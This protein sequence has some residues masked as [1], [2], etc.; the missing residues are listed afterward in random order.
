MKYALLAVLTF[1]LFISCHHQEASRQSL[2]IANHGS[3]SDQVP[4]LDAEARGE[5][6]HRLRGLKYV[7]PEDG[8]KG[9][10]GEHVPEEVYE[11][12]RHAAANELD[13]TYT[14]EKINQELQKA[15]ARRKQGAHFYAGTDRGPGNISGRAQNLIVDAADPTQ[16]TW[17]VAAHGG[18]LWRTRN[19]GLHWENLTENLG[20]LVVTCVAQSR[21]QPQTLYIGTGSGHPGGLVVG[22]GM[23][24]SVDSGQSWQLLEST[25]VA[26]WPATVNDILV[27][28][29]DPN[30]IIATG[31]GATSNDPNR[32]LAIMRSA[33]GG[34]SWTVV[35]DPKTVN[36]DQWR[37]IYQ[38]VA[39]PDAFDVLYATLD[40]G[41]ILRSVDRGL[42]WSILHTLEGGRI[43]IALAPSN[44][45]IIYGSVLTESKPDVIVSRDGG[46]SWT[47]VEDTGTDPDFLGQ[48]DYVMAI[49]VHPFD[50]QIVYLSGVYV[51]L[52]RITGDTRIT[53]A[54]RGGYHV[55]VHGMTALFDPAA[56][57]RFRLLLNNDGGVAI[58]NDGATSW[59]QMNGMHTTQFYN[60]DKKPGESAYI[61][62]MQDNGSWFLRAE[63]DPEWAPA[64]T[65]DGIDAIWHHSDPNQLMST[66]QRGIIYRSVD[67]GQY[68]RGEHRNSTSGF[69]T[70]LSSVKHDPEVIYMMGVQFMERT[71]DFGRTWQRRPSPVNKV[72][73]CPTDVRRLYGLAGL[74]PIYMSEDSGLNWRYLNPPPITVNNLAVHPHDPDQFYVVGGTPGKAKVLHSNNGGQT[75]RDLSGFEQGDGV[76]L[77]GFPDVPVF[78][79][80]VMPHDPRM[81]WAGTLIGI[82]ESVDGGDSW[83]LIEG[84]P[85]VKIS[86]MNVVD[87]QIVIPTFGRGVWTVTLPELLQAPPPTA[88]RVPRLLPPWVDM[89]GNLR[90]RGQLTSDF[91]Q[92]EFSMDGKTVAKR[93]ARAAGEV[94]ELMLP[95]D[96]AHEHEF[97]LVARHEGKP[98]QT[99]PRSG[100]L[101][102][103][104]P[105]PGYMSNFEVADLDDFRMTGLNYGLE[106]GFERP[107][108]ATNHRYTGMSEYILELGVPLVVPHTNAILAYEDVLIAEA[109]RDKPPYDYLIVEATRD[110]LEWLALTEPITSLTQPQW[111]AAYLDG[112]DGDASMIVRHELDLS[113]HFAP[114]E[115]IRVRFRMDT[116]HGTEAWGW[117]IQHLSVFADKVEPEPA[118]MDH[119]WVFPWV[120]KNE[121]FSSLVIINNTGDQQ[122][123]VCLT[124][125]REL[126]EGERTLPRTIPAH[127][128]V[129]LDVVELFAGLEPGPGF[130]VTLESDSADVHG[131]LVTNN[132]AVGRSPSQGVA[133]RAQGSNLDHAGEHLVFPFLPLSGGLVSALA[134]V[135]VG[136]AS[137]SVQLDFYDRQG[138]LL[139]QNAAV[140]D[141]PPLL[142][143]AQL[144][145]D[146]A[147]SLQHDAMLLVH[148]SGQPLAGSA[149]IFNHLGETA[150]TEAMV[151]ADTPS[152]PSHL[153]Y[154]W[155]SHNDDYDS[156]VGIANTS[157][158]PAVVRLDARRGNGEHAS[159]T[160]TI[161]PRGFLREHAANLFPELGAGAGFSIEARSDNPGLYG[162]WITNNLRAP[163]GSSPSQGGAVRVTDGGGLADNYGDAVVFSY[164]PRNEDL[165]AGAVLINA[166][167]EAVD[168]SLRYFNSAGQL[169]HEAMIMALEPLRPWTALTTQ[170][171]VP[172]G[173]LTLEA[174]APGARLTGV[175]FVFNRSFEP[176]IG[177]VTRIRR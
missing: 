61:G 16:N 97:S 38:L 155:V 135:N 30:L 71:E 60:A 154:P 131:R 21:S 20:I 63:Q 111:E 73:I 99:W 81:I 34:Q 41:V 8:E 59:S 77:N 88:P 84:L 95:L 163:S 151:I 32:T 75:Y 85:Y 6:D 146:F 108:V 112:L 166:G 49:A 89:A 119:R 27:D 133:L 173:D 109:V 113:A 130:A 137:T 37:G 23:W 64:S 122:A 138:Q 26:P 36:L 98:Y 120:S 145:S 7:A 53:R 87:D 147:P 96:D 62:G 175:G 2:A 69:F 139:E 74:R 142:P 44:P 171:P 57:D 48:D 168:V 52:A 65:G 150:I 102:L 134:M 47:V 90:L 124:A 18:G 28:P 117:G 153:I 164:L 114:G 12:E 55:D 174:S 105:R 162:S 107:I 106:P 58:S 176:S 43:E 158:E 22:A 177:S 167:S 3:R 67:G 140:P 170:L 19:A 82:V 29:D 70:T 17:L 68:F 104:R 25:A 13:E 35:F 128:F 121:N 4:E 143:L 92:I 100:S 159:L 46:L 86:R 125:R 126:G 123:T 115:L 160:Q 129:T 83:H 127:G 156:I 14:A 103:E 66:I 149:F 11:W 91:E 42:T 101:K 169:V 1:G 116:D 172:S 56:P 152:S 33:D 144:A 72:A 5:R 161:P 148:S 93:S 24:K 9:S 157:S 54:L 76:S 78:S 51:W 40:P 110:G 31:D 165:T 141:L 136:D 45:D 118:P 132:L 15:M 39:R 94:V 10:L 80:L 50:P 79:L